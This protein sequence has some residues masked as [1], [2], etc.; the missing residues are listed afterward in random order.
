[1][2][3][4][5]A[6]LILIFT[7]SVQLKAQIENL[8][9][10]FETGAVL[11]SGENLPFWLL[12]NR[13]GQLS[14]DPNQIF[15]KFSLKQE[16]QEDKRFDIA[17][18]IS[19]NG[20]LDNNADAYFEEWY[21][22]V[23][24]RFLRLDIG[25]IRKSYGVQDR[26]LS[27]GG[28]L[29]SGNARPL[30]EI[31]LSTNHYI[32]IPF[33]NG[34]IQFNGGMSHGW[35]DDY[36]GIKDVWLHH[37]WLMIKFGGESRMHFTGGL[38]HFAQWGGIS[39]EY[40]VLASNLPTFWKVFIG[41]GGNENSPVPEQINAAGNHLGS[42]NFRI[43][44]SLESFDLGLY[45]ESVFE[46]NSGRRLRNFPDG[47]YGFNIKTKNQK[48]LISNVLV[49]FLATDNQSGPIVIDSLTNIPPTGGDN[50]FRHY[51][52]SM[53][54]SS[55]LMTIG[56]PFI[57]S[58]I[59]KKTGDN[60]VYFDNNRIRAVHCGLNGMIKSLNYK[61]LYSHSVNK[62]T[63][64][65]PF[66]PSLTNNSIQVSFLLKN[67]IFEHSVFHLEYAMDIGEFEGNNFGLLLSWEIKFKAERNH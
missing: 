8:E 21:A 25:S 5:L 49:E 15:G 23:K 37:K 61:V 14:N 20:R 4:K 43:D 47:L 1:M 3:F 52:Y 62:G 55:H 59:Y 60:E 19:L 38:H 12:S 58:P 53:G 66:I 24:Y 27:S 16:L 36:P 32:D 17:Y 63:F 46:D 6:S 34:L 44:Y 42:Y 51:I 22:R 29:W 28:I 64:G 9:Y 2:K 48:S 7:F 33:T 40:G 65:Q 35:F 67:I 18:G 50:Y 31:S 54:W 11:S 39:E 56:T 26:E 10:S 13:Y 45:W 41:K 57:S 30:P